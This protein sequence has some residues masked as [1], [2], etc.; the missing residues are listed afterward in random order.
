MGHNR[1]RVQG[2]GPQYLIS[3]LGRFDFANGRM[4][5]VSYHPNTNIDRI[6][7]KTGF[8]LDIAPDLCETLLPTK[9][10]LLL[11]REEI[12]P[13]GIRRLESLSGAA[14]RQLLHAILKEEKRKIH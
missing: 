12:D 4:R 11:L 14:R 2:A 5:L 9:E 1:A 8:E 7:T 10:E 3:D 6:Q 13:L